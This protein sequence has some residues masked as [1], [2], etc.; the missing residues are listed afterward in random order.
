MASIDVKDYWWDG[1][2]FI[3]LCHDGMKYRM[4]KPWLGSVEYE[5]VDYTDDEVTIIMPIISWETK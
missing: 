4:E 1:D 3:I 2:Y 5:G